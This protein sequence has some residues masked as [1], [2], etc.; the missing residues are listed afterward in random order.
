MRSRSCGSY[1]LQPSLSFLRLSSMFRISNNSL[2]RT[3]R[4]LSITIDNYRLSGPLVSLLGVL[5]YSRVVVRASW[6]MSVLSR[7]PVE[8]RCLASLWPVFGSLRRRTLLISLF[9]ADTL[10][11]PT[12]PSQACM[13]LIPFPLP[14]KTSSFPSSN[15][16][17]LSRRRPSF[18]SRL[19][20]KLPLTYSIPLCEVR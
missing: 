17:A 19:S 10:T 15:L 9:L 1:G 12:S 6:P 11:S 14:S 7:Y 18:P 16:V 13:G 4:R 3:P 2:I 8:P 20:I 5:L